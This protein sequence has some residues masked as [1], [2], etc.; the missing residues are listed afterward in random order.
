MT[1]LCNTSRHWNMAFLYSTSRHWNMA[2]FCSTSD[3]E[4]CSTSW[5][6]NR[7]VLCGT[8]RHWSMASYVAPAD[9]DQLFTIGPRSKV[10]LLHRWCQPSVSTQASCSIS[11]KFSDAKYTAC[12]RSLDYPIT[13]LPEKLPARRGESRLEQCRLSWQRGR[14]EDRRLRHKSGVT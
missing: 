3:T 10:A 2:F 1:F 8:S 5:H 12:R 9:T 7:A 11:S 4:I 14:R 6:W 13:H